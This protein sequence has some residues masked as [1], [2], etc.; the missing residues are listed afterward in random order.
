MI[1]RPPR[2][3]LS[4]SSA[5]SDVYKRQVLVGALV[6]Q[7]GECHRGGTAGRAQ[8]VH[9]LG[10]V[11]VLMSGADL[12]LPSRIDLITE[13]AVVLLAS[14]SDIDVLEGGDVGGDDLVHRRLLRRRGRRRDAVHQ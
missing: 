9:E 6:D 1:R 11:L 2:S 3:T 7:I 4:S 8:H 10:A 14:R 13:S 12:E 5:A